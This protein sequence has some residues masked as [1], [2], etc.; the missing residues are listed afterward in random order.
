M[1]SMALAATLFG[2][3]DLRMV[4]RPLDPLASGMVRIRFGAGGICGSDMH[5]YRDRKS[6]V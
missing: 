6:V 5:Y 3:E 1:T 2:P 4:E